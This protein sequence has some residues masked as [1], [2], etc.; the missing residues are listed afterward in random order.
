MES[1]DVLKDASSTAIYGARGANGVILVT[2]KGAKEGKVSVSYNGY[3]KFNTPTKYLE[4]LDPYDYLSFVWGNAAAS[5]DAYRLPFEKLYGIG[6]Y[7]G[8]NTEG[9]ESYRNTKNYNI[10]KDVYNSS[11]SHNHDLSV[12]GGTEKTKVLFAM[13][14]MDEQ[15]MK[16]NSYAKRGGVS[17][18]INQKLRDNLDINLDTR[19]SDMRTMGDEGTTNGSGSLLSSSYRFRPIATRDILGDLNALREGNMEMYGRQST[20]DTYSP[21]ARIGDYDPLYIKQR[22]RGT[23]SLNWRL[24]DGFAYHT[25]FTL[26]QSWEQDK[27]WGGLFIIIIWMTKQEPNYMREMWNIQ[28]VTVG[29]CVGRIQSVM[30]SIFYLNSIV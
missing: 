17:L 12:S 28:S 23:L 18:K 6:D 15:G 26:N 21:V 20:W 24:F 7:L 3:V 25:D 2:T 13:N 8:S 27:I 11:V 14:Y 29:D 4:T 16:L 5:G 1:I 9:I 19:Y 22:L 10:Q 30:T